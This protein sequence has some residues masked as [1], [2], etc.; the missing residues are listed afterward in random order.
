MTNA[1]RVS[2]VTLANFIML[3]IGLSALAMGA[4]LLAWRG[5]SQSAVQ[6]R[7]LAGTMAMALGMVLSISAFALKGVRS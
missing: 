2:K 7:R 4:A 5:G 1:W 6:V 3:G